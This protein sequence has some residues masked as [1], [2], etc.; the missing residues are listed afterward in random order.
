M[1]GSPYRI[2]AALLGLVLL[3]STPNDG[4]TQ[5][6][7]RFGPHG[8]V[9]LDCGACH[10]PEGWRPIKPQTEFDHDEDSSF[11]LDGQH[12]Q[13]VCASCHLKLR[14]DEPKVS[15]LG[16]GTCHVDVHLGNLSDVCVSCHNTFSFNDV[17]GV[18]LHMQT[19]FPLTG[20]HLQ[21]S[22]ETCH[23]T[24]LGGA[25]TSLNI[26]CFSCHER[27]YLAAR[28]VDHAASGFSTICQNCHDTL[29][30]THG[31]AFDHGIV[32]GG[33]ELIGAHTRIRCASCHNPPN[34][35]LLFFPSDQFDCIACHQN[36]FQREHGGGGFPTT[37]LDCHS[38]LFWE[39]AVF[40]HSV[41][42]RG[43]ALLGAHES[44]PCNKCHFEPGMELIFT[45]A[46]QDDCFACHES[47]YSREHTGTGFPTTCLTCHDIF[48]WQDATFTDHDSQFFAIFSGPHRG[49][50]DGCETCHAVPG[51]FR[52]HT[53]LNCH[54]HDRQRM[55][56][57][58][59]EEPGYAY[60]SNLCLQCHPNGRK[61]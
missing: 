18:R 53:C 42:A 45:P 29:A 40:D 55:D 16:C 28:P 41:V 44:L 15:K 20:A 17:P 39:G 6:D 48:D 34:M 60:D 47:A 1:C 22:C 33:F 54:E 46:N 50:W 30:W 12:K 19:N 59:K 11:R 24:D 5:S 25:F 35:D 27:E 61:D 7:S 31:V 3:C 14:F 23:S 9:T 56:D 26:D 43:F 13:A 38:V 58:H 49:K 8:D 51:D 2:R 32:S 10:T 37:C 57:K 4:R 21:I 36:D 52:V